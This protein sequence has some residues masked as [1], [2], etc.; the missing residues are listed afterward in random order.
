MRKI[1]LLGL[2][3]VMLLPACS[4]KDTVVSVRG[5]ETQ[6]VLNMAPA[7]AGTGY[8]YSLPRTAIVVE[9][10][11]E[12]TRSIPGPYARYAGR[13]LG[14][15]NIITRPTNSY[16]ITDIIISSFAEPDPEHVYY[17]SLPG[18]HAANRYLNFT[19]SGLL[20]GI[21]SEAMSIHIE[22]KNLE[23]KDFDKQSA[24]ITFNHFVDINLMERIDTIIEQVMEDTVML[25]RQTLRRSWVEKSTEHRAREVADYILELREK[26]FDLISGFQEISYSKEALEY[27]YTEMNKLE[28]D[29]LDLFTGVTTHEPLRYRFI[30]R[31]SQ[32]DA[33]HRHILFSFSNIYG[34][35]EPDDVDGR[36]FILSYDRSRNTEALDQR[37]YRQGVQHAQTPHGIHY[38]IPEYADLKLTLDHTIMTEAR[39]L[40][41][42]FGIVS[43]LPASDLEIRLYPGSGSIQSI[44]I[45]EPQHLQE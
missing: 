38:R 37:I 41:S 33:N 3:V 23:T 44:G 45:P 39:M 35:L 14:L 20:W 9:V 28:S 30:H 36:P 7:S 6:N 15:N 21:G 5:T 43:H 25:Q 24:D 40:I 32:N 13:L 19:E 2:L 31:P 12:K 42:Q 27:M 11:V 8:Y 10:E 17:V 4:V 29:Y 22:N 16:K 26:K 18:E 34:V 1:I